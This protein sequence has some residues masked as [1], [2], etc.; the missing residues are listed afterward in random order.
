MAVK[1]SRRGRWLLVKKYLNDKFGVQVHFS[2]HHNTYYSA[3]KYMTKGESEAVHSSGHPDLT[4]APKTEAAITSKKQKDK[5][6]SRVTTKKRKEQR[7]TI[8]PGERDKYQ[9]TVDCPS[10]CSR[11]RRKEVFGAVYC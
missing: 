2:D 8:Y 10:N 9:A 5:K 7:L 11:T 4:S 1:L 6:D 3:Y